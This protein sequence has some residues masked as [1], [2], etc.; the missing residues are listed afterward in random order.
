MA[1]NVCRGKVEMCDNCLDELDKR[2]FWC[3]GEA[4]FCSEGCWKTWL[5]EEE[6]SMLEKAEDDGAK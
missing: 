2:N 3:Y 1:C 4:H 5:I 6:A